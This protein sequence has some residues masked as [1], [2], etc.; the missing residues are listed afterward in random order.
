[1]TKRVNVIKSILIISGLGVIGF[2]A[3]PYFFGEPIDDSPTIARTPIQ[4]ESIKAIAEISTI[5]YKDEI[6]VDSV[7]WFDG[8]LSTYDPRDWITIYNR[9]VKRRLT[10]I[11]RGEINYGLDLSD[12][13]FKID[14][15]SLDTLFIRL[16]KA[17]I[18]D[19]NITPKQTEIFQEQGVWKDYERKILEKKAKNRLKKNAGKLKLDAKAEKQAKQL[20]KKMIHTDKTIII[21]FD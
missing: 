21:S 2:M 8:E 18:L 16:P 13:N 6:V 20:V 7:E 17:K 12:G 4:I 10:M 19:I 1:M 11:V 15:T 3:Y 14:Q 9:G 5:N